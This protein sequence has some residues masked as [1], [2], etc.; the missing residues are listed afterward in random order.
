MTLPIHPLGQLEFHPLANAFPLIEGD[1][2]DALTADIE[3]NGLRDKITLYE[4]KIL[5]GRNR[6]RAALAAGLELSQDDVRI[7]VG[8]DPLGFVVSV[9]LR[10]RH[11]DDSQRALVAAKLANMR[12][13]ERTDL[14][15]RSDL[16]KLSQVEAAKKLNVGRTSVQSAKVVLASGD[17]E[18]IA[19]VEKGNI[20]VS[21]A[22]ETVRHPESEARPL[23]FEDS[24]RIA[25][26]GQAQALKASDRYRDKR[27]AADMAVVDGALAWFDKASTDRRLSFIRALMDKL[28]DAERWRVI[29]ALTGAK[30][31]NRDDPD[32]PIYE[33][34]Q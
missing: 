32:G 28:T 2:F 23:T 31:T 3:A 14:E 21:R 24:K 5:D 34:P 13:G 22:A 9:N 16:S 4:G 7:F 12:Q 33:Y 27:E 17:A 18:L 15:P 25:A 29:E 8:D 11:L 19:A 10:R 6:Y 1:E 20:P 26:A 30:V